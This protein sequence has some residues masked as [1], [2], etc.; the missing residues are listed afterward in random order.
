MGLY[1]LGGRS[2]AS[3][4]VCESVF[5]RRSVCVVLVLGMH[6]V[7]RN[8]AI[9]HARMLAEDSVCVCEIHAVIH[10]S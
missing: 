2:F 8:L 10:D 5:L 9:A 1:V 6:A 3:R 7:S 4:C